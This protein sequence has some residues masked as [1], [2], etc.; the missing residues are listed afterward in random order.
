MGDVQ[1]VSEDRR[2]QALV[3]GDALKRY[4]RRRLETGRTA[5]AHLLAPLHVPVNLVLRHAEVMFE[6]AAQPQRR[7]L[8]I[9][10]HAQTFAHEVLRFLDA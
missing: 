5:V 7:G 4:S 8:L 6:N 2:R 3:A 9:L 1:F 10:G